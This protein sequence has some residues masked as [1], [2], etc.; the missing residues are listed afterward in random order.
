MTL[1]KSDMHCHP[2]HLAIASDAIPEK[3]A[4]YLNLDVVVYRGEE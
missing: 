4:N 3:P 1:T 2:L